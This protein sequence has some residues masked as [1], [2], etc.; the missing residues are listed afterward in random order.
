MAWQSSGTTND[1]MVDNLM[2]FGVVSSRGIEYGFRHVDRAHFVPQNNKNLAHSD[3]PL[4]EGNIHISA[5]HIYGSVLEALE[6]HRNSSLSFLNVGSGTGYVSC[7][8]AT[9][10]GQKSNHFS[11]EIHSDVLQHS[12]E[13]MQR[14]KDDSNTDESKVPH[15]EWIHGNALNIDPLRGES[16]VGFDRIYVGASVTKGDLSNLTSLL[17]PGG[18]L[19][20]P[21]DDELVKV[22]RIGARKRSDLSTSSAYNS[23]MQRQQQKQDPDTAMDIEEGYGNTTNNFTTASGNGNNDTIEEFTHHVLSGVRFAPLL[24]SKM[25]RILIPSR[26]WNP[27]IHRNY[28]DSFRRSC[29]EILLCSNTNP[30]QLLGQLSQIIVPQQQQNCLHTK[31]NSAAMLPAVLWME[32]LSYAHRDWFEPSETE[33]EFLR[34]RLKEEQ[35]NTQRA[36]QARLEAEARYQLAEQ[37]RDIYRALARRCQLRFEN[38][39]NQRRPSSGVGEDTGVY[40]VAAADVAEDDESVSAESI[41][42]GIGAAE[43]FLTGREQAVIFGLGAMLRSGYGAEDENAVPAIDR[44][45]NTDHNRGDI[46]DEDGLSQNHQR[47]NSNFQEMEEDRGEEFENE[48][49]NDNNGVINM[50]STQGDALPVV[51]AP[52]S[53]KSNT[54]D[55]IEAD[56][57]ISM[58]TVAVASLSSSISLRRQ[59]RTVSLGE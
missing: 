44:Y 42:D 2:R 18:I 56:T 22:V 48:E 49:S 19:V 3:Q 27:S 4:K 31:V 52:A 51:G 24:N 35:A 30:T 1:E 12:I 29:K 7:I 55:I 34:R 10:L 40:A 15:I 53:L 33:T 43:A 13:S 8:V 50:D 58:S 41:E 37:E 47:Y 45:N 38:L 25:E 17:R 28:P 11:V 5:P 16:V 9:I 39:I 36:Q 14:W 21:V 32:I 57:A 26:V 20:G 59:P 6:L 54:G 46:D 23:A